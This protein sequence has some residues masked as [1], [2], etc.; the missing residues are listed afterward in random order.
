MLRYGLD[1]LGC[2]Q[3]EKLA[4][5]ALK[6]AAGLAVESWGNRSDLGRDAYSTGPLRFPDTRVELPGPFIF[7]VKFVEGANAA[8]AKPDAAVLSSVSKEIT[9][10]KKR[11]S[12]DEWQCPRH[13]TF[14]TNAPVKSSTR[15]KI[16]AALQ[17]ALPSTQ[18][19]IWGGDDVCDILDLNPRVARA[20][21]QLLSIR[22]LD[23]LISFALK[24]QSRERSCAAIEVARELVPVFAPTA[25]YDRAWNVLQKHHFA[26]LEGP[27]EVGKSAI[28][29]MIG[30]TQSAIGWESIVCSTPGTFFETFEPNL[31]QVFIADDAFGRTEYDPTRTSKWESDL[32]LIL[33]R[34]DKRHWLIWTS[35]KHILERACQRMDAQ[36]R[37][38]SFP[39]PA[40]V[41]IDV[42]TFSM[43]EKAVILFRHAKAAG[44]EPQ[45]K[46]IIRKGA[47]NIVSDVEF[48]PERIR[49]FVDEG[50][51]A[52]ARA[53]A[54]K[55]MKI[56]Q[57]SLSIKEMLRNP[58]KQ[59]RLTFQNLPR[60]YKWLLVALLEISETELMMATFSG[61]N[62]D[63]LKKLYEGYCPDLDHEPFE[64]VV[65]H[66][67]E[68]FVKARHSL[69]GRPTVDWIHPSYRDLVIDE[70]VQDAQLRTTF[71]K[72]ASLEGIK[73]AI[74]DTGGKSGERRLPF[75]R[76][77]ESWDV[78]R[79]RSLSLAEIENKQRELLQALSNAASQETAP[80]NKRRW[81]RLLRA[82]CNV[83]KESWDSQQK[84]LRAA[85][86]RAFGQAR[87]GL[88]PMPT[89][90]NLDTTWE[91]LAELFRESTRYEPFDFE[92]FDELTDFAEAVKEVLP[93]YLSLKG[94]PDDYE[95]EIA[96][97]FLGARS[98]VENNHDSSDPDSLRAFAGR[99]DEIASAIERLP[100]VAIRHSLTALELAEQLR[101][102][103]SEL[104]S[105]AGEGDPPD[106]E[107]SSE[108][109]SSSPEIF[110]VGRLFAEL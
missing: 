82:V 45:A 22:D 30:L 47:Q 17:N 90:P 3:F 66:L 79:A 55:S 43:E 15:E 14:L 11:I 21:P 72:R 81:D 102:H 13:Y 65:E 1:D 109:R 62:L 44:L 86:L 4:Q 19:L 71:L 69:L 98:E 85:D 50:L 57:V 7:Q 75:I 48:T 16:R 92:P 6:A 5:S 31:N 49:R 12:H 52:L 28:A 32:D 41:L 10:I 101:E 94:F 70:L 68:A 37:A 104:E 108:D 60:A 97:V 96:T 25:S 61:G 105:W 51:P 87:G 91:T 40:S 9:Q 56:E 35:R 78:L 88:D 42:Q 24:K 39:D 100:N 80:D 95:A 2:Y 93:E 67:T 63:K 8:G 59:M 73:L 23:A 27:P 38:R 29:W 89:L 64:T 34:V 74:S 77:A 18:I 36:G 83:V 107:Y 26:V 58:T 53:V 33:H 106:P 84:V 54:S 20:F 46:E 110:D 76:S 99:A 103:S